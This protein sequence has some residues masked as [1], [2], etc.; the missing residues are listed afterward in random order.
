MSDGYSQGQG[1]VIELD[2]DVDAPPHKVWRAIS[3]PAFRQHWLP[4]H[5]LTEP[6]PITVTPGREVRYRL[7]DDAPPFL[8]STVTFTITP[9]ENGG[10]CLR[11]IQELTDVRIDRMARNTA[12]NNDPT[13][14]SAA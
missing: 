12:N 9:N 8:E 14:K 6:E 13:L 7:H 5:A 3:V 2:F 11:I 10:T 4:H 1:N